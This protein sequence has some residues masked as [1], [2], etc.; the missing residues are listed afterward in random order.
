MKKGFFNIT[1][2]LILVTGFLS[3]CDYGLFNFSDKTGDLEVH[4]RFTN[5]NA[6]FVDE[7]EYEL[8]YS[9]GGTGSFSSEFIII[10]P[11]FIWTTCQQANGA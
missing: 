2:I 3:G 11:I 7:I 4:L 6:L 9:G 5:D 8:T 10:L 1:V